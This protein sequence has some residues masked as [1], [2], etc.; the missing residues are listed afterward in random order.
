MKKILLI[1]LALLVS[2]SIFAQDSDYIDFQVE[3]IDNL[4]PDEFNFG[5]TSED[6]GKVFIANATDK[7]C[8]IITYADGGMLT[9]YFVDD[10]MIMITIE[11]GDYNEEYTDV[12]EDWYRISLYVDNNSIFSVKQTTLNDETVST[13]SSEDKKAL[14]D[15]ITKI[16]PWYNYYVKNR[17]SFEWK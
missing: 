11:P 13:P 12:A 14:V 5:I 1:T 3:K 17:Y 4:A 15:Y 7:Y 16:N 8:Q 2:L 9:Y 6:N 10:K